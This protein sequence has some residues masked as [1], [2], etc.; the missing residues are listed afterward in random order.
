MPNGFGVSSAS[1]YIIVEKLN[2][3]KEFL[4]QQRWPNVPR[5][6]I[7]CG[8]HRG[9]RPLCG[10]VFFPDIV[11]IHH[12]HLHVIIQPRLLLKTFKYPAWLPLMWKSDKKVMEEVQRKAQPRNAVNQR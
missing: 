9:R 7:H 12:I 3:V 1:S 6:S 5:S 4:I 8:Y 10:G 11:S 2:S